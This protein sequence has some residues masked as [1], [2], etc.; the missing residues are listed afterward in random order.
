MERSFFFALYLH[1][2]LIASCR[3]MRHNKPPQMK[4]MKKS[5]ITLTILSVLLSCHFLFGQ[6]STFYQTYDF[7]GADK[8]YALAQTHDGGYIMSGDHGLGIGSRRILIIKTDSLGQEEWYKIYGNSYDNASW[9]IIPLDDG[10][11]MVGAHT[12]GEEINSGEYLDIYLLRLD[13]FG[14]TIWTKTFE[15]TGL[16]FLNDMKNCPDK[17]FIIAGGIK[18]PDSLDVDAYVLKVDSLGQKEWDMNYHHGEKRDLFLEV[19][20]LADSGFVFSG[21]TYVGTALIKQNWLLRTDPNGQTIW[22]KDY[23]WY[24]AEFNRGVVVDEDGILT[25]GGTS[26]FDSI[27]FNYD[28]LLIKVNMNGDTLWTKVINMGE[29]QFTVNTITLSQDGNYLVSI[30]DGNTNGASADLV[31]LKLTKEGEVIWMRTLLNGPDLDRSY[32]LIQNSEG[33]IVIAG[34]TLSN[35]SGCAFLLKVTEEG[36]LT[37]IKKIPKS[38]VLLHVYPNPAR[39]L[40]TVQIPVSGRGGAIALD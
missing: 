31:L 34:L 17:G 20:V 19:E 32:D 11:Y 24:H 18:D 13:E 21:E 28:L 16:E 3:L 29:K 22:S 6:V 27:S 26:S 37:I 5:K 4:L 10:G 8:A 1:E 15:Q 40:I 9:A 14:D 23:G 30:Y 36:E 2:R 35:C 38:I 33:A 25:G 7:G 12:S 39:E